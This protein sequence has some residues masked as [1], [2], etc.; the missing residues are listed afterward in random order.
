VFERAATPTLVARAAELAALRAAVER[1]SSGDAA[2]VIVSGDAGVG[3]SRLAE[4]LMRAARGDG[5]LVLLGRCVDV[6]D[7]ELAYAPIAGALRSL[8]A[9]VDEADLDAVLGPGREQR[10]VCADRHVSH[11]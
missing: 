10:A 1:A 8:A 7:G 4:E 2:T 3:K 5:T 9:Q 6:G 11:G